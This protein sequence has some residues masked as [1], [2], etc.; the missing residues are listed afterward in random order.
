MVEK[1]M[2]DIITVVLVVI[3]SMFVVLAGVKVVAMLEGAGSAPSGTTLTGVDADIENSSMQYIP[4]Q[5]SG[6]YNDCEVIYHQASQRG[7]YAIIASE[8]E[9]DDMVT[10]FYA[11]YSC[12]GASATAGSYI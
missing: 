5:E 2:Q 4:L 1:P 6:R 9:Q 12:T 8:T 3:F 10:L 11:V 7:E